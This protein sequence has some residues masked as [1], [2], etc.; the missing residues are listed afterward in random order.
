MFGLEYGNPTCW[1]ELY[2]AVSKAWRQPHATIIEL[3][4]PETD[5]AQT[6]QHLLAQVSLA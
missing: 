1:D 6:L 5:G 2:N 3:N 4:V